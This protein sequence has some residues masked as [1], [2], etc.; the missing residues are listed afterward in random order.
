MTAKEYLKQVKYIERNIRKKRNMA[1]K[2]RESLYGKSVNYENTGATLQPP[3]NDALSETIAKV[4]DYEREAD[5]EIAQLV[6]L[7]IEIEK[8]ILSIDNDKEQEVLERKYLLF[9]SDTQI[10]EEMECSIRSVYNYH[11]SGLKKII[12]PETACSEFQ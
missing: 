10:A 9:E 8:A 3:C 11:N 1:K 7:R 4:V 12:V 6:N 2:L 5:E